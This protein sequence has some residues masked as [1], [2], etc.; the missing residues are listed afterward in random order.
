VFLRQPSA[1][2]TAVIAS[3]SSLGTPETVPTPSAAVHGA[4]DTERL[5][6]RREEC[7]ATSDAGNGFGLTLTQWAALFP[8]P[9]L[10]RHV[11]REEGGQLNPTWVEWLMG[12]PLEWTVCEPSGTQ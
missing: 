12:F 8:K 10:G 11:K 1:P 3:L 5:Q 7:K 2:L 4:K 9:T 6:E